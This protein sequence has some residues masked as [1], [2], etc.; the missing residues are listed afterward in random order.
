MKQLP[1][2]FTS[3]GFTHRMVKRSGD[4]ALFERYKTDPAKSHFEVV[5]VQSHNGRTIAGQFLPP[6]EFYPS[7][8]QWGTHGFTY[9]EGHSGSRDKALQDAESRFL[10]LQA[11]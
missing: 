10:Q 3:K 6:A 8:S 1:E 11:V 7:T 5:R 2:L 4:V 9:T